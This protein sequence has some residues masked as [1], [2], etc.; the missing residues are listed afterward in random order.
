MPDS[1]LPTGTVTFLFTDVEGSTALWEHHPVAMQAALAHHDSV[2]RH[3]IES[4]S[5]H[6][7]KTTGDGV[8]AVFGAAADALAACLAI[9][10]V[11]QTAEAGASNPAASEALTPIA[12]KV[13]MGLHTGAAEFRDGDYFGASL[14]RAARIRVDDGDSHRFAAIMSRTTRILQCSR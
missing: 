1:A 9:Q 13:R 14:N 6:I 2:L 5:G 11:L 8:F 12:L 3:A 4:S 7:V 10:R